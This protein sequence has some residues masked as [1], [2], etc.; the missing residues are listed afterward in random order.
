LPPGAR[1]RTYS[2][3]CADGQVGRESGFW[4]QLAAPAVQ[5]GR[6]IPSAQIGQQASVSRASVYLARGIKVRDAQYPLYGLHRDPAG[7]VGIGGDQKHSQ[8]AQTCNGISAPEG[9]PC[10]EFLRGLRPRLRQNRGHGNLHEG[11]RRDRYWGRRLLRLAL[12]ETSRGRL[13]IDLIAPLFISCALLWWVSRG[14]S[15]TTRLVVTAITLAVVIC[16]V[17]FERRG[18]F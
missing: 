15:W 6:T 10:R 11:R 4:A 9:S 7:F 17:L 3:V 18:F 2:G 16:I 5:P 13:N 1:A 8:A 12:N 14:M